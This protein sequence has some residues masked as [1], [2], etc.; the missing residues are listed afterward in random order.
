MARGCN[1]EGSRNL[2]S[3]FYLMSVHLTISPGPHDGEEAL[4]TL[5]WRAEVGLGVS[6][7]VVV[8]A[9]TVTPRCRRFGPLVRVQL[10]PQHHCR[11]LQ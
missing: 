6:S 5:F 8:V 4:Q 2:T 1:H 11:I 9:V 7:V 10:D 3:V